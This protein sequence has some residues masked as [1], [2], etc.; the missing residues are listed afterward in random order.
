MERAGL[1]ADRG[2][3][4]RPE[5]GKPRPAIETNVTNPLTQPT[6]R[7]F[8]AINEAVV[9]RGPVAEDLKP[10]VLLRGDCAIHFAI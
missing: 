5:S 3:W 1:W 10:R 2:T 6:S 9:S 8:S 4:F 7:C